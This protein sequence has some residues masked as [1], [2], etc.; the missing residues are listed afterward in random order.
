MIEK[1]SEGT[2]EVEASNNSDTLESSFSLREKMSHSQKVHPAVDQKSNARA[3]V[4][5]ILLED[6]DDMKKHKYVISPTSRP[7]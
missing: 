2:G 4:I 1:K 3:S 5:S 7:R 6:E